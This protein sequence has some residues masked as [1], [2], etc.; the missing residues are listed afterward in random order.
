MWKV[1]K[2]VVSRVQVC[3]GNFF[4]CGKCV[5]VCRRFV[6]C[7]KYVQ[8]SLHISTGLE[9]LLR[10]ME[11]LKKYLQVCKDKKQVWEVYTG[12]KML[13]YMCGKVCKCMWRCVRTFN[14][15]GKCVQQWK[16]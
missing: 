15:F 3:V 9:G 4:R 11:G 12:M 14:R 6:R 2:Y 1:C 5:Q 8:V 7:G 10:Y 16:R 13:V